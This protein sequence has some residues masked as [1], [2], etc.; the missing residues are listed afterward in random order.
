MPRGSWFVPHEGSESP[1]RKP[2]AARAEAGQYLAGMSARAIELVHDAVRRR[3]AG[4]SRLVL[5]VSGG[6]D[7][8]C[9]LEAMVAVSPGQIAAVATFDHGTGGH[10]TA[11][12]RL[13]ADRCTALGVRCVAGRATGLERREAGWRAR[14]LAFLADVARAEQ[15]R[16]ATA[17]HEDDQ[18]E[19]VCMRVLRGSGARG[20]AGLDTDGGAVRPLLALPRAAIAS[21]ASARDVEWLDDPS[22]RSR[23]HLR[24]RVRLD[25]LPAIARVRPRFRDEVLAVARRAATWRRAM[26]AVAA[27]VPV[28]A[29]GDGVHV[30]LTSQDGYDAASLAALWPALAARAGIRLDRRGTLRLAAFTMGGGRAGAAMQLSGGFEV[31]RRRDGLLLRLRR[32]AAVGENPAVAL[33]D[34]TRFGDAGWR[35]HRGEDGGDDAWSAELPADRALTVRAWRAGDRMLARRGEGVVAR[36]VTRFFGDAGIPG[37]ERRGWPV[38]LADDE[39]VWIPGVRRADAA[40]VRSGRPTQRYVCERNHD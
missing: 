12:V 9:L 19:T 37:A 38:V 32:P 28:T 1:N 35:F 16:I 36:R 8:M 31:V 29:R 15:A 25:L 33:H 22:N 17:H 18:L 4:E 24:N 40:S 5:A 6:R 7:S 3:T 21:Y 14:R 39:V 10:A 13:V 20:L 26:E 30:A 11:A 23:E 27:S 2:E 34:G